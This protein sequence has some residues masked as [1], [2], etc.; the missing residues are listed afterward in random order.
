MTKIKLITN[1]QH[2]SGIVE[3]DI[4]Q[5]NYYLSL[6][7][8]SVDNIQLVPNDLLNGKWSEK[9]IKNWLDENKINIKY[10]IANDEK[11]DVINRIKKHFNL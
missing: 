3:T 1:S 6:G 10:D 4:R 5:V 7:Y 9:Q 2:Q 11:A 8:K